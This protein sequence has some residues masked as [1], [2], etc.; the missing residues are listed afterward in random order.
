[1]R[2]SSP[3][4]SRY[5]SL[6]QQTASA[7]TEDG[8]GSVWVEGGLSPCGL[9]SCLGG[10]LRGGLSAHCNASHA[11]GCCWPNA[12]GCAGCCTSSDV[13]ACQHHGV[14]LCRVEMKPRQLG[15]AKDAVQSVHWL[16]RAD[17][18]EK[19]HA[20]S[21]SSN[22]QISGFNISPLTALIAYAT[23]LYAHVA[24]C[25]ATDVAC[26]RSTPPTSPAHGLSCT[27]CVRSSSEPFLLMNH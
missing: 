26:A 21:I 5:L 19:I 10:L 15:V 7:A 22:T 12:A 25:C 3:G 4:Q 14:Q 23:I 8:R 13:L 16:L 11:R 6:P 18:S 27:T 20:Q 2:E 24:L 9:L 1:V 17:S